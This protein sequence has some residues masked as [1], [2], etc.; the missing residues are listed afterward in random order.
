MSQHSLLIRCAPPRPEHRKDIERWLAGRVQGL[1][2]EGALLY[3]FAPPLAGATPDSRGDAWVVEFAA[4]EETASPG[5][6]SV[7]LADMRLL[8][9]DPVIFRV[10][11]DRAQPTARPDPA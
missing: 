11:R 2:G 6:I 9:L 7:L 10:D 8:G 3:H 4:P 5:T 1:A